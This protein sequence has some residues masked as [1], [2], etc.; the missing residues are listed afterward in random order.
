MRYA[1]EMENYVPPPGDFDDQPKKRTKAAS[2]S[3]GGGQVQKRQKVSAVSWGEVGPLLRALPQAKLLNALGKAWGT[4]GDM[5][6]ALAKSLYQKLFAWVVQHINAALMDPNTNMKNSGI[7]GILDIYGFEN[8]ERNSLEQLFINFTNEQ[9]HQHFAISLFKTEQDIYAAEGILWPGVE[10]EDNS[11]CLVVIAGKQPSSSSCTASS[12][13]RESSST[14][15]ISCSRAWRSAPPPSRKAA[16]THAAILLC[17]STWW[18]YETVAGSPSSEPAN[19][20]STSPATSTTRFSGHTSSLPSVAMVSHRA[21]KLRYSSLAISL[22]KGIAQMRSV[23]MSGSTN[24]S[25]PSA[26]RDPIMS[27]SCERLRRSAT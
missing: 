15:R 1:R 13:V 3:G 19:V 20:A 6:D 22:T 2:A 18:W 24:S 23:S 27:S 12:R 10:W 8:F 21:E 25:L 14:T 9:L 7:L 5:R 17:S 26:T 11:E 16:A 4:A